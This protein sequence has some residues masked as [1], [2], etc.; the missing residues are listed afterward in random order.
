MAFA[1]I[2]GT[3]DYAK[4]GGKGYTVIEAWQAQGKDM[5][6]RWAVWFDEETPLTVGQQVSLSGVLSTKIGEPWTDREGAT[7][8]GG[9]E[10]T[11]NKARFRDH[12]DAPAATA[13]SRPVAASVNQW[14]A[15]AFAPAATDTAE[16]PF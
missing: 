7:R 9:V 12:K 5:K 15:D 6:R 8:P 1:N 11:I 3:V 2:T 4:R 14:E 16:L 10:H 13:P